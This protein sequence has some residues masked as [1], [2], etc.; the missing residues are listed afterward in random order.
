MHNGKLHDQMRTVVWEARREDS[1]VQRALSSSMTM[2]HVNSTFL[3]QQKKGINRRC[4]KRQLGLEYHL[5]W[6]WELPN[7]VAVTR[8]WLRNLK[9]KLV[10]GRLRVH[11]PILRAMLPHWLITGIT[12]QLSSVGCYGSTPA[13]Y[14]CPP[15]SLYLQD[16]SVES[17]E[18]AHIRWRCI[19]DPVN[20]CRRKLRQAHSRLEV[21]T[22]RDPPCLK[23]LEEKKTTSG[24]VLLTIF[25]ATG[26][27][28][29]VMVFES[30][31]AWLEVPDTYEMRCFLW[32]NSNE[33]E[34]NLSFSIGYKCLNKQNIAIHTGKTL[35]YILTVQMSMH[36]LFLLFVRMLSYMPRY[37]DVKV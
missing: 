34:L 15:L 26:S 13:L 14:W 10:N 2:Y 21:R 24:G 22:P 30:L 20:H 33:S 19:E 31:E 12:F 17:R 27:H 29:W 35:P 36:D 25:L 37:L 18:C 16:M 8:I 32:W 23:T 4:L 28:K 9:Q 7:H 11:V 6:H 1:L 3:R 5:P